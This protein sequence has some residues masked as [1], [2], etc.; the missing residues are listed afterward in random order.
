MVNQKQ[1]DS[2]EELNEWAIS[3]PVKFISIE[4]KIVKHNTGL[5]LPYPKRGYFYAEKEV[6]VLYYEHSN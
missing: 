6:L 5:P 4:T 1:F 3:N 2:L